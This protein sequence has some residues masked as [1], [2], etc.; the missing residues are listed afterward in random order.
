MARPRL[1]TIGYQGQKLGGFVDRLA[2]AGVRT[3]VDVRFNPFSRRPEFSRKSLEPALEKAAIRYVHLKPLG[4]PPASRAA[5][6]AGDRATYV[7]LFRA[8][9]AT[10]AAQAA[11]REVLALAGEAAACLMCL[12]RRPEDCHRAMVA[13]ALAGMVALD[14]QH[15]VPE[16]AAVARQPRLL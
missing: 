14:V 10:P 13:D 7:R 3:L 1:L 2:G 5:A 4:N 6:M 11:L 15:L 8:H 16:E 12:E 9:L